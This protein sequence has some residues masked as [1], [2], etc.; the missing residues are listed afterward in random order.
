MT[1]TAANVDEVAEVVRDTLPLGF[2]ML[3]FQPAAYV[4]D[5]RRWREDLRAITPDQVWR[6]IER[7][8]GRPLP[9]QALQ[10][11]DP[12]C[13]RTAVGWLVGA[14][15]VPLLEPSDPRDLR[16]RDR[17]LERLG[18]MQLGD[19]PWP[20]LAV[21][22]LRATLCNADSFAL[23]LGWAGRAT[24]RSGGLRELA[25][26]RVRPMTFVMHVFMDAS[27]VAPAWNLL[28]RGVVSDD[29]AVLAT[30]ERLQACA[31]A[32]AHPRDGRL[33]PACV[34]HSVLDPAE[35]LQLR[36]LLP[37]VEVGSRQ[38]VGAT[39]SGTPSA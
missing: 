7:G 3:S 36:E 27:D 6:E 25:R 2:G 37:L 30:Q 24:R 19:T 8:A 32:M 29:P 18:G 34:Q 11:G 35:N 22:L 14:R 23:A 1:V 10:F 17:F 38:P 9:W 21:K 4:G 31:Y 26:N 33:V 15:W 5:E 20:T 13:N 16:V 39:D 28:E 12:R